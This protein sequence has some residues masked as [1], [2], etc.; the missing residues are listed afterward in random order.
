MVDI[1]QS[2]VLVL[3]ICMLLDVSIYVFGYVLY[4]PVWVFLISVVF[5]FQ[6]CCIVLS[7]RCTLF[8]A[9]VISYL[10]GTYDFH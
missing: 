10:F 9:L 5:Y 6:Q 4:C 8:S 7:Q 2:V 3:L 1:V